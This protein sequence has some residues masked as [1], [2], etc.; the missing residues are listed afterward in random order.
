MNEKFY[1]QIQQAIDDNQ[2][3]MLEKKAQWEKA[4]KVIV[5]STALCT[6]LESEIPSLLQKKT[7]LESVQASYLNQF[8]QNIQAPEGNAERPAPPP[9]PEQKKSRFS[10]RRKKAE[11]QPEPQPEP[12]PEKQPEPQTNPMDDVLGD[13]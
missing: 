7:F 8:P 13:L 3:T 5:S 9:P 6:E 4:K 2:K 1:T 12:Q 10:L 11:K